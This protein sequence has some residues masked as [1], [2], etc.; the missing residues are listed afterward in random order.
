M[1]SFLGSDFVEGAAAIILRP[2][3]CSSWNWRLTTFDRSLPFRFVLVEEE[4]GMPAYLTSCVGSFLLCGMFVC[5]CVCSFVLCCL[6][7]LP[8]EIPCLLRN[9]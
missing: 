7:G 3:S 5:V 4:E 8:T 6:P 2:E 1:G 9:S